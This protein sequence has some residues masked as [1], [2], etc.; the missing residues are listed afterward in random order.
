MGVVQGQIKQ[1]L[2]AA[3]D[4]FVLPSRID[5]FGIVFL[6]AWAYGKPVI[7]GNAGGIPDVIAHGHD[8]LLVDYGDVDGLADAMRTL[9]LDASAKKYPWS[10][11]TQKS[12]NAIYLG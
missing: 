2:L 8:G 12:R 6:E 7:G 10:G 4:I 11:R 9:L 5:S 3:T 1:D